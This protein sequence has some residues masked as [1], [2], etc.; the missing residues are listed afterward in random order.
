MCTV[1]CRSHLCSAVVVLHWRWTVILSFM[2]PGATN[3]IKHPASWFSLFIITCCMHLPWA[4]IKVN[5]NRKNI[6]STCFTNTPTQ[7]QTHTRTHVGCVLIFNKSWRRNWR[8]QVSLQSGT[9]QT[10]CQ[11]PLGRNIWTVEKFH[12]H[13][14]ERGLFFCVR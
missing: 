4:R 13:V 8:S 10:H 1:Q 5:I 14:G 2:L 11:Q 6:E 3:Q 9:N 7:T 12:L